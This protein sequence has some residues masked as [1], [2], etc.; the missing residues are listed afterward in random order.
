[1]FK[2][3][4]MR[5]SLTLVILSLTI[6][7]ICLLFFSA[8]SGMTD[9]MEKSALQNMHAE[10]NAQTTLIEEY[11]AHQ[12]DLLKEYSINP[13][14][15]DYLKDLSNNTQ[16]KSVQEYTENYY[17]GLDN[18]EGLYVAEWN[19]HVVAHSNP[20]VVG[21]TTR[22]GAGLKALQNEMESAKG[23][24]NAGIIVSP[25]SQKLTLSMYCP[26]YD[27]G[28]IIGYVGG[29]PF[30]DNLD[31]MLKNLN[32]RENGTIHYSMINVDSEM[33]IFHE[34]AALIATQI[35]DDL[36]KKVVQ[37]IRANTA[38]D[39]GEVTCFENGENYFISYQYDPVHGWAVISK[40]SEKNLFADVHKVMTELAVIC[41][42]S[43]VLIGAL[44]WICIYVNTKPLK[45]VT[46]ALLDLKELKIGKS[47]QLAKYINCKSEIGLI[48]TALDSL[49]DSLKNIVATLDDCSNS[50]SGSANKMSDSSEIL[51]QCVEENAVATEQFAE[52]TDRINETV[53]S[54]D[55]GVGEI[56]EVVSQVEAK[57]RVGNSKS[58]ELMVNVTEMR[59]IA[60]ASLENTNRKMDENYNAIQKAMHDLQSLTQIDQIAK[61]ILEITNQTNLLS[62]NASIEAARAG[63]AGRG[64]AIVAGE[65]GELANSSSQAVAEIQGI[66]NETKQNILKVEECFDS[67]ISFMEKD[68]KTQLEEFVR[69]TDEYNTSISQIKDIISEMGECSDAFVQ[70]VSDIRAQIDSVQDNSSGENI[71]TE[72]ILTKVEHTR[73]TTEDMADIVSINEKNAVS[74]REIVNRFTN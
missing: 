43:S 31:N 9:L 56:A 58:N 18:W 32:G 26:V 74:I 28:K 38:S 22:E 24:Y 52:H 40:A 13:L 34:D 27:N 25:A 62:L 72:E 63:E 15:K 44:S 35:Q 69:A 12:E 23:L 6:C 45:Y 19:T 21:I 68:V 49:T 39:V 11:L 64:F 20:A 2:N 17:Q 67:I 53:K 7:C 46:S 5:L 47:E 14:I 48:A 71:S 65:I 8:K 1:M 54:V 59:E 73:K 41:I 30:A 16:Q 37:E 66:C 61:R 29:G 57:I 3:L 10:L 70:A 33:Y 42:V 4:K 36:M 55:E 50:L 51:I 60:S